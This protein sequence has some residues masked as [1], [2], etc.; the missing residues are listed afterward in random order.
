MWDSGRGSRGCRQ[1]C[2]GCG[3]CNLGRP[4]KRIGGQRRPCGLESQFSLSEILKCGRY[5]KLDATALTH[6]IL[7]EASTAASAADAIAS[8]IWGGEFVASQKLQIDPF[9]SILEIL[10]RTIP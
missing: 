7:G 1:V 3:R 6:T 8:A 5:V 9:H 4:R 2:V 10:E